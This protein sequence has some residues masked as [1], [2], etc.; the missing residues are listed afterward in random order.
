MA[1][2][3]IASTPTA[4][5]L[6]AC[7]DGSALG[8]VHPRLGR[9]QMLRRASDG[10]PGTPNAPGPGEVDL[11]DPLDEH[12]RSGLLNGGRLCDSQT[13]MPRLVDDRDECRE[14]EA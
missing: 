1:A 14:G 11:A 4:R 7:P 10:R 3:A 2:V 5:L 12:H 8:R 13:L 6:R 9:R